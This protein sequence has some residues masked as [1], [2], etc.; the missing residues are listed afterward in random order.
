MG[1]LTTISTAALAFQGQQSNPSGVANLPQSASLSF[2][3]NSPNQLP[4]SQLAGL[5]SLRT[6]ANSGR[7]NLSHLVLHAS[8]G[9]DENSNEE[10]ASD[11]KPMSLAE[12]A[13]RNLEGQRQAFIKNHFGG[14]DTKHNEFSDLA[15]KAVTD[16]TGKDDYEVGDLSETVT[17]KS[18]Q[19]V[20]K[21]VNG[22]W[23]L[24]EGVGDL[25]LKVEEGVNQVTG[26]VN[27]ITDK[28]EFALGDVVKKTGS[29]VNEAVC[30][31]TGKEKYEV[32]DIS[33]KIEQI[34]SDMN[35][36]DD[37]KTA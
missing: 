4:T 2:I 32:G 24:V 8:S 14:E 19:A 3:K 37:D 36:K 35:P 10:I 9:D 23:S 18:E 34:Y 33:R 6:S 22:V 31:F 7:V 29:K 28:A 20:N 16:F 5:P 25:T 27:Q 26:K 13:L 15:K 11:E 12:Q 21:L 30:D 1:F 17:E